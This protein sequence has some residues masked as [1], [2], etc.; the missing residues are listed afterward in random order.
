MALNSFRFLVI[1]PAI[2]LLY[3]V[4]ISLCKG[5]PYTSI[6]SSAFLTAIS[7]AFFLSEQPSGAMFLF[8]VTLLT[9]VFARCIEYNSER[10]M[11][12]RTLL[13]T[14]FALLA[15][16]PLIVFK[17]SAFIATC[18]NH[19]VAVC[20]IHN[21]SVV[22]SQGVSFVVPLGIS[23]FTF[24]AVGYLWDVYR[25]RISAEHNFLYYMLFVGFFP[26]I[27]SGP[28]SSASELLPQI[29]KGRNVEWTDITEGV[30]LMLMGFFMKAVVADRIA[31]FVNPVYADYENFSGTT[32]FIASVFYSLQIYGDFAGYSLIAIGVGHLF[33]FD[34]IN[35]FRRPYLSYS[36]T[37][38]WKRWHISL[39]RWLKKHVY[40]PLG[41]NR[42]GK[43][44][45][46]RNIML[47]FLVSGLWHGAN[48]TFI[49][50]GAIHGLVLCLER[51]FHL[52]DTPRSRLTAFI[53]I[54]VTFFIVNFAWIF[55][56][57]P[58]LGDAV[59][60]IRRILTFAQ[61]ASLTLPKI[62]LLLLLFATV[63]LVV[64]EI[65]GE[66]YPHIKFLHHKNI[67]IRIV[68][69]VSLAFMILTI[70][71]LDSSQFIYVNF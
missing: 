25:G 30:K 2:V 31:T 5:K 44:N 27:A 14:A 1:L 59:N 32:C 11:P 41:G 47:T 33:G 67:F 62:S 64:I 56:R 63:A 60:V 28:I 35:N 46:Y 21:Y 42:K 36:V 8:I 54:A 18:F 65:M 26:Q 29:K 43:A 53:R 4:V 40:I 9:Y 38:F 34:L 49:I 22:N 45:T 15:L 66:Y 20:G 6:V 71:V 12:T 7:Y 16:T 69:V 52:G 24:Q 39:T 17:Y 70:G 55:F 19:L 58:T 37:E 13:I 48:F 10:S 23:F 61:G 51:L 68:S 50:W 57:M 3:I